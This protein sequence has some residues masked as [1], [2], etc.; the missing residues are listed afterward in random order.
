MS[1]K[2]LEPATTSPLT[3]SAGVAAVG[4]GLWLAVAQLG[5]LATI[6][7]TDILATSADPLFRAFSIAYA[8]GFFGLMV[9]LV[10]LYAR[11][12]R[13]AG[14]FGFVGFCAATLGTM[15]LGAN[16]WFEAFCSPWLVAAVPGML[17]LEKAPIWQF[18]YFSSYVLFALG[19]IVFGLATWA[20]R[21]VP[22]LLAL[23]IVLGGAIGF[24]AAQPPFAVPLGLAVAA[25]GG[26][27]LRVDRAAAPR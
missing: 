9:A 5:Q 8:A 25:L 2:T 24:F 7:R 14:T 22:A 3:R 6:D 20:S 4:A 13:A 21:V 1:A 26:W 17:T 10:A 18:G 16:M 27:L 15:C 23:A 19:W 12:A 11:Q